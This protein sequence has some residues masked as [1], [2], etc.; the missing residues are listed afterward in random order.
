MK[1]MI[2]F[3]L[4]LTA[5]LVALACGPKPLRFPNADNRDTAILFGSIEAPG[6]ATNVNLRYYEGSTQLTSPHVYKNGLWFV[7]NLK[8]GRYFLVNFKAN[9]YVNHVASDDKGSFPRKL[10]SVNPGDIRF[11]GSYKVAYNQQEGGLERRTF[12][13]IPVSSPSEKQLLQQL[14]EILKGTPWEK[15]I[16]KR[17]DELDKN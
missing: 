4:A 10:L 7:E 9:G 5:V 17:L 3:A 11:A 6:G 15:K 14:I 12:N 2:P 16:R 8:P 1:R 13:Y